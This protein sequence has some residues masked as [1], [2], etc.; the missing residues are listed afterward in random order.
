MTALDFSTTLGNAWFPAPTFTASGC[1]SSGRE[2][3]Q[4]FDIKTMG[5]VVT[6]SVMLKARNGRAELLSDYLKNHFPLPHVAF[7]L[8]T[9]PAV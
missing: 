8:L 7:Q 1:A 3:S 4:F 9:P 2:L 6:K 5:G